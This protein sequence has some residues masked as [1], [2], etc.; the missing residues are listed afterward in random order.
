[1][2]SFSS[3]EKLIFE[4]ENVIFFTNFLNFDLFYLI[5]VDFL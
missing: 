2:D 1:M 4:K 3:S 5:V